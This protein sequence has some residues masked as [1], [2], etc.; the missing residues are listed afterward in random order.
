M[1]T[2]V[3]LVAAAALLMPVAANAQAYK[4]DLPTA[5][6]RPKPD[7][8]SKDQ[9]RRLRAIGGYTLP[10]KWAPQFC[11]ERA[12]QASAKFQCGSCHRYGFPRPYRKNVGEGKRV[13]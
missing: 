5:L 4:C 1:K 9:P 2:L 13:C 8:P 7:L 3:K 12:K 11:H 10:I 6:A